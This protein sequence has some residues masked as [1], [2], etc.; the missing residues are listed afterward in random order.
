MQPPSKPSDDFPLYAHK[1]G[2]WAKTVGGKKVY[3]GKW[4][5]P[6]AAL[7]RYREQY[8]SDDLL[9]IEGECCID[10][11]TN[12]FLSVYSDKKASGDISQR[13]WDEYKK[14]CERI[15]K[16]LGRYTLLKDLTPA[17]FD[18]LRRSFPKWSP[19]TISNEVGRMKVIL[20]YA[21]K[22]GM[23]DRQFAY[24]TFFAKPSA[25][26]MMRHRSTSQ[27][28]FWEREDILAMLDKS[29]V[30][31][32]AFI[33][34]GINCAFLPCDCGRL[35]FEHI[36]GH[37]NNYHREKSGNYR[38]SWMWVETVD[39]IK[40]SIAKRPESSRHTDLVF[41]TKYRNPWHRSNQQHSP[42]STAFAKVREAA[43]LQDKK[44][45]FGALRSTFRTIADT[46]KDA[47]R[48]VCGHSAENSAQ[49]IDEIY[50]AFKRFPDDRFVQLSAHVHTWLFG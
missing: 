17:H 22:T 14:S 11:L 33:L 42:L 23:V 36:D 9:N 31:M 40:A 19:T 15:I 3:F 43:K 46:D 24:G 27:E 10:Y 49:K 16:H 25:R 32:K 13:T 50:R 35:K 1:S 8:L 6:D 45:S 39:A 18:K 48:Y 29:D 7:A 4:D 26:V 47:A 34:L 44:I 28:K 30:H 2:Q 5:D 37:W 41:L 38:K 12:E 21:H 20:N